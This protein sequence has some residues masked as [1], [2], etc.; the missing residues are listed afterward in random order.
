MINADSKEL[1][2]ILKRVSQIDETLNR[3]LRKG[4]EENLSRLLEQTTALEAL[5]KTQRG[6][7]DEMNDVFHTCDRYSCLFQIFLQI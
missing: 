5:D 7:H 1:D 4:V 3:Q 2:S 6:V